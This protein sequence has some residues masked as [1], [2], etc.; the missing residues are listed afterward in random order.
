MLLPSVLRLVFA[1]L[2]P[3]LAPGKEE[4]RGIVETK[5]TEVNLHNA[6]EAW[7]RSRHTGYFGQKPVTSYLLFVWFKRVQRC[8]RS[9][10]CMSLRTLNSHIC[11][12]YIHILQ[13]NWVFIVFHTL[14]TISLILLSSSHQRQNL[15]WF[16]NKANI[17]AKMT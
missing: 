3:A 4:A 17:A 13:H 10:P 7:V 16:I 12:F 5:E 6:S 2:P 9:N 1:A 14:C 15:N 8:Y 11:V